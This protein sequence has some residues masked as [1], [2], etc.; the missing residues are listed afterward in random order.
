MR[1]KEEF[2]NKTVFIDNTPLI[3]FIEGH[4]QFQDQL[5]KVFQANENGEI[6]FQT[7]TLTLLEV[8]VQPLKH[9]RTDLVEKYEEILSNS[10]NF[11]IHHIGLFASKK[12][13]RLMAAYSLKN[14]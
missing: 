1:L 5:L 11:E 12:A 9:Q 8:L 14:T 10:P 6:H 7:P 3:Y 13:G 4:S 2:L